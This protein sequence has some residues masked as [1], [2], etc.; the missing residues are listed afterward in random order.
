MSE[1][2]AMAETVEKIKNNLQVLIE[3]RSK[4]LNNF[5]EK[6]AFK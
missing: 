1:A 5:L 3:H 2:T 4:A 6:D